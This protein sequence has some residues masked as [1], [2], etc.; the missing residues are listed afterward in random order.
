MISI[1][2]TSLD[3][4]S[5]LFQYPNPIRPEVENSYPLVPAECIKCSNICGNSIFVGIFHPQEAFYLWESYICGRG[6][7]PPQAATAW[8]GLPASFSFN[9]LY[10]Q[11][12]Q[13]LPMIY[14]CV[15]GK[16]LSLVAQEATD[17]AW[18]S[19][20]YDM[21]AG[22]LKFLVNSVVDTLPSAANLGVGD[23]PFFK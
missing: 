11:S 22:T 20:L 7:Y 6:F 1:T 10:S 17:F 5:V 16:S 19:F 9:F 4:F 14:F 13:T 3:C 21:K 15:Q 2:S 12:F 8:G 23:N 18:K